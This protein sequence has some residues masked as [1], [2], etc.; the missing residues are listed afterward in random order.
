MESVPVLK[1]KPSAKDVGTRKANGIVT[2]SFYIK[3]PAHRRL[4][5]LA[6]SKG[7]TLQ[8]IFNQGVDLWLAEH[9]EAPLSETEGL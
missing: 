3:E 8:D 4:K 6:S 9:S 2:A 5:T 1:P 7:I